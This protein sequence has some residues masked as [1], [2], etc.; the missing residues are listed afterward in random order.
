M[1]K[2]VSIILASLIAVILAACGPAPL[3]TPIP[4]NTP[5]PPTA[6]ATASATPTN[7]P[8]PSPTPTATLPVPRTEPF[9]ADEQAFLRVVHANPEAEAVDVFVDGLRLTSAITYGQ[10]TGQSSIVTG[11]YTIRVV[12]TGGNPIDDVI[13]QDTALVLSGQSIVLLDRKSVV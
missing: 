4:T 10:F 8:T 5:I 12:P 7:T 9:S 3:P 13:V 2:V 6:T 11:E 1:P